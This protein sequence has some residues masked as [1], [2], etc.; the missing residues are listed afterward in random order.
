MM[1][2]MM[3][4]MNTATLYLFFN[5][6]RPSNTIWRTS[7]GYSWKSF[8]T[9][10]S[11]SPSIIIYLLLI[12]ASTY[13]WNSSILPKLISYKLF[14]IK[15]LVLFLISSWE[16]IHGRRE[17]GFNSIFWNLDIT[18]RCNVFLFLRF[19]RASPSYQSIF[20]K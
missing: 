11:A 8:N 19:K 13:S 1:M 4:M 10:I 7:W 15:F 17:Y 9:S 14:A 20:V 16:I 6:S 3:M 2:M 12:E 5:I 18:V